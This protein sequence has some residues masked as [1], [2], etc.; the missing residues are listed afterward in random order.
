MNELDAAELSALFPEIVDVLVKNEVVLAYLHGSYA[1]GTATP[2]SDLDIAVLLSP[3]TPTSRYYK[4]L[5]ALTYELSQ[6]VPGIE[7]D[8]HFLNYA[9]SEFRYNVITHGRVLYCEDDQIRA[10]FETATLD[11]YLDFKYS[12]DIYYYYM[13]KRFSESDAS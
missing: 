8:V 3:T 12:L 2:L 6:L 11:E 10:E 9:P 7:V 4:I 1:T 13:R 5:L